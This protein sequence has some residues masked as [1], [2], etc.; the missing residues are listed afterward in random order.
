M[1]FTAKDLKDYKMRIRTEPTESIWQLEHKMAEAAAEMNVETQA[2]KMREM[3]A[4]SSRQRHLRMAIKGTN[5]QEQK[6]PL[7]RE[8][9]QIH[10]N[11]GRKLAEDKLR[12][13]RH[14]RRNPQI[15]VDAW[16]AAD[17]T[18]L[19]QKLDIQKRM[20]EELKAKFMES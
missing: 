11:R 16:K 9:K 8:W 5:D 19:M 15:R 20:T 4:D 3:Q 17:G 6:R 7:L 2:S 1:I 10:R 13:Q 12:R 18:L 14:W